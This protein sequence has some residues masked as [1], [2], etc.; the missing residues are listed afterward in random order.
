MITRY[1][2][3]FVVKLGASS[4]LER[5]MAHVIAVN[6]S[7]AGLT[8]A[9]VPCTSGVQV[10]ARLREGAL[11]VGLYAQDTSVG[12][13]SHVIWGSSSG[14]ALNDIGWGGSVTFGPT[15]LG[16][17]TSLYANF[18]PSTTTSVF[19]SIDRLA[20]DNA[21]AWPLFTQPY[22]LR[23]TPTVTGALGST[24]LSGFM[25]EIPSWTITPR[26]SSGLSTNR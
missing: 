2:R 9:I 25:N 17:E 4:A 8:V 23:W 20:S 15:L 11:D 18:N 12:L 16:L 6:W 24:S 26:P 13:A 10:T 7:H 19:A 21:L 1:G 22:A 3:Q 5:R 14:S